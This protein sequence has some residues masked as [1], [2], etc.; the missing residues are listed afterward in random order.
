MKTEFLE[1]QILEKELRKS[2]YEIGKAF[3]KK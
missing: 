1:T 3:Q 2:T